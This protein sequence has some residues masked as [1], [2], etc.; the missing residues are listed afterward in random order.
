M[1]IQADH[2]YHISF[3]TEHLLL[4]TNK[5]YLQIEQLYCQQI[6]DVFR[7]FILKLQFYDS[8]EVTITSEEYIMCLIELKLLSGRKSL[9]SV[10]T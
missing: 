9:L 4:K 10:D 5:D 2:D 8:S 6:Y 7:P 1:I 3:S